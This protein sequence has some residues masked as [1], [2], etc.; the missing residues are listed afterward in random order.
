MTDEEG[1]GWFNGYYDNHGR[2]VEGVFAQGVRMM[3]TSQVFAVMAQT[4]TDEQVAEIVRSADKYLYCDAMGGYRLNT[5][6]GEVKMDLGRMFGFAYG[7][8]ENGAVFSHMAVMFANALYKRGFVKEGHRALDALYRQSV[9]LKPAGFIRES[10]SILQPRK[11]NV[12]LPD[13]GGKL[14]H[15]YRDYGNVRR[16]GMCRQPD[17]G[18][19]AGAATV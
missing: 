4:A 8:K 7:E 16:E 17:V 18:T 15:A 5:D 12:S 6:F 19:E 14:V 13:G 2:C 3:L 10:R 1:N 11:G 9:H